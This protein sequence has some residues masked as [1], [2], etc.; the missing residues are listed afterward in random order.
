MGLKNYKITLDEYNLREAICFYA[1]ARFK[2]KFNQIKNVT[3]CKNSDGLNEIGIEIEQD[4]L[5]V[6]NIKNED[7]RQEDVDAIYGQIKAEAIKPLDV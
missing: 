7:T 6:P 1:M 4:A 2:I 3:L 5:P